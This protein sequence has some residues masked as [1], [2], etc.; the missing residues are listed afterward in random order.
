MGVWRSIFGWKALF[1][2]DAL[3]VIV[4]GIFIAAGLGM[5]GVDWFPFHLLLAQ[6]CFSL[7]GLLCLVKIIGHA[8][9]SKEDTVRSRWIFGVTLGL[10]CLAVTGWVD[11]TIQ[12]HEDLL[13]LTIQ[14][15]P[16]TPPNQ[17]DTA[18]PI[19]KSEPIAPPVKSPPPSTQVLRQK[20]TA[21][22]NPLDLVDLNA[23][24]GG[25]I[26]NRTSGPILVL[27]I[28]TTVRSLGGDESMSIPLDIAIPA[29]DTKSFSIP[30]GETGQWSTLIY[31]TADWLDAWSNAYA[32]HKQCVRPI[33]F[34]PSGIQLTQL[35]EHYR[36]EN[37]PFPVGDAEAKITYRIRGETR[38]ELL[39]MKAVILVLDGCV[40]Q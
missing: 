37:K 19:P 16:L 40:P 39:P 6:I 7:A 23:F 26:Y 3:G 8:V 9:E 11:R 20:G 2:W 24:K 32:A 4:P 31:Q 30:N 10:I 35:L 18:Q 25:S 12:V 38:D 15:P 17:P 14:S 27:G 22:A 33:V 29:H 13:G 36:A 1:R 21:E 34:L 5:L 28:T